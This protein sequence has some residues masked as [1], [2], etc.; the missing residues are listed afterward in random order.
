VSVVCL[1]TCFFCFVGF[2]FVSIY[3]NYISF[4]RHSLGCASSLTE[5]KKKIPSRSSTNR[6]STHRTATRHRQSSKEP[7]FALSF[8]PATTSPATALPPPWTHPRVFRALGYVN[9][10]SSWLLCRPV[11]SEPVLFHVCEP[12]QARRRHGAALDEGVFVC[13]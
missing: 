2:Y 1:S 8:P 9:A 10:H 4:F 12:R 13:L 11:P 7:S 5:R 3:I 6:P